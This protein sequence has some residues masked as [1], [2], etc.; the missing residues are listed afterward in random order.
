[1]KKYRK[2][3][4]ILVWQWTGDKS[5]IAEM[6]EALKSFN[7]K[8][9]GEKLSAS[10]TTSNPDDVLGLSHQRGSLTSNEFVDIGEYIIFDINDNERPLGCYNEKWLNN[11]FVPLD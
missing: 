6:N 1:M 10:M 11:K 3:N 5:I 9:Q 2:K 4:E 8:Y 7:D